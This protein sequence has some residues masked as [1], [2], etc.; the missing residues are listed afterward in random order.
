VRLDESS[1]AIA[2]KSAFAATGI[3]RAPLGWTVAVKLIGRSTAAAGPASAK[4]MSEVRTSAMRIADKL[5]KDPPTSAARR[6]NAQGAQVT[7][8]ECLLIFEASQ[9]LSGGNPD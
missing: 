6:N 2:A 9:L 8:P 4:V 1:W 7:C 3:T 5:Q